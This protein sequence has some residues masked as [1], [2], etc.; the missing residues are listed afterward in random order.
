MS[1]PIGGL[2]VRDAIQ[3]MPSNDAVELVNWIAQQY[4]VRSRKGYKEWCTGLGAPVRTVMVYQP[5]RQNLT[6]FK[7]FGVTDAAVKDIT[8]PSSSP[9]T[10]LALPGTDG[11]GYFSSTMYAN[12]A[13][14]FLMCCSHE[15]GYRYF[16]GTTWT[17]PAMG[18]GAGQIA[19]V[20]PGNLCFVASWKRRAWFIEKNSARV[21]YLPTDQIVGAANM[22]DLGPFMRKGGKLSFIATWT[23][24][25]GEGIDDFIVFGSENGEILIYKGVNPDSASSFS[26]QGVYYVGALPVGR[27]AYVEMGGD[28]LILSELGIQPLSYVT[29]GGQ[30]MLRSSSVDYLAKIQPKLAELV[31]QYANVLGWSLTFFPRENFMI[32]DVPTGVTSQYVQYTLYTNTN[33][34]CV[35]NGMPMNGS[36]CIANNQLYF[37]ADD[38][39]VYLGHEGYFDAVPLGQSVGN[40][41]YGKIQPAY[42]YFGRVGANKQFLMARPNFMATDRPSVVCTMLADF[43]TIPPAGNPVASA[44]VGAR[45]DISKWDEAVWAGALNVFS[46]WYGVEALGYTGSLVIDTTCPGD[47]F[48]ASIDYL[49]ETGGVL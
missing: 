13:G 6:N 8:A 39:K 31:S 27:R 9:A 47:T 44:P 36:A 21:W 20:D 4:G 48:L 17:T 2:N 43:Q 25:A 32:V 5:D 24:D 15:G 38:G 10:S 42:S 35:F 22:L 19:N 12:T 11:Y 26:L 45:W 33:T 34:W 46:D 16:N 49:Y 23:I 7:L 3:S 28:L 14:N 30:S 1:A 41:I 29:R 40:G 37:G 18:S